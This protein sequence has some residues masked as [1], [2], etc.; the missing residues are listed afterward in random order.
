MIAIAAGQSTRDAATGLLLTVPTV[1]HNLSSALAKLGLESPGDLPALLA[2]DMSATTKAG[3][4]RLQR[5]G[6][7]LVFE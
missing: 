2:P 7:L 1:E 5:S 6:G 4:L 3:R